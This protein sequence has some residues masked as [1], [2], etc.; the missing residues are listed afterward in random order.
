MSESQERRESED[1]VQRDVN[2]RGLMKRQLGKGVT[3][4]MALGALLVVGIGVAWASSTPSNEE[5]NQ[6][7]DQA[8]LNPA[9]LVGGPSSAGLS[10][11]APVPVGSLRPVYTETDFSLTSALGDFAFTRT[12]SASTEASNL[13]LARKNLAPPFG[14]VM[15]PGGN[16][17]TVR[18]THNLFSYV[19]LTVYTERDPAGGDNFVTETCT[20]HT[21]SGGAVRFR[22]CSRNANA[23][24]F[25]TNEQ[26]QDAKLRWDGDGFTPVSL[27]HSISRLRGYIQYTAALELAGGLFPD[28]DRACELWRAHYSGRSRGQACTGDTS[29]LQWNSCGVYD[30]FHDVQALGAPDSVRSP[31]QRFAVVLLLRE[32]SEARYHVQ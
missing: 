22:D 23:G 29:I 31:L 1:A 24:A 4:G 30:A 18:W 9:P 27:H 10:A 26:E 2:S 21:P 11:S 5:I 28:L 32:S 3:R 19:M 17:S 15:G 14:R 25:A 6:M 16:E 13:G 8:P 20:V 7:V 12:S